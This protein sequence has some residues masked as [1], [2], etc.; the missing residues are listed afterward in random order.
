M[1][2]LKQ[3]LDLPRSG[4]AGSCMGRCDTAVYDLVT[5]MST[6]PLE[7]VGAAIADG[8][9]RTHGCLATRLINLPVW[10]RQAD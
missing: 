8:H 9:V 2:Q 5:T 6:I 10:L 4:C 7:L 1:T 3:G